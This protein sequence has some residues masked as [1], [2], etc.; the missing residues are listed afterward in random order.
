M[1]DGSVQDLLHLG[2]YEDEEDDEHEVENKLK[3]SKKT[4]K[5]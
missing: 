5:M 2:P 1:E 3:N 4:R